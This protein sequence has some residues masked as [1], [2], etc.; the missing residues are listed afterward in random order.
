MCL[1]SVRLQQYKVYSRSFS[2]GQVTFSLKLSQKAS[3]SLSETS[4][5]SFG[6]GGEAMP[7][8]P[9][10][11]S[12]SSPELKILSR[13]NYHTYMDNIKYSQD[14]L[15][16]RKVNGQLVK[17]HYKSCSSVE[18]WVSVCCMYPQV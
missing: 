5:I 11:L 18:T 12:E 16:V 15:A 1:G 8:G 4:T 6:K 2:A 17:T 3:K 7:A 9:P 13:T 10:S 14:Q